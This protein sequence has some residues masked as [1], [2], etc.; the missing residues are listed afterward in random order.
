MNSLEALRQLHEKTVVEPCDP[1]VTD[2]E[3]FMR[4]NL[5]ADFGA[6]TLPDDVAVTNA[7]HY[8]T[9]CNA[10]TPL[11]DGVKELERFVDRNRESHAERCPWAWDG[12]CDCG[13]A[14]ADE[15]LAGVLRSLSASSAKG[16]SPYSCPSST[17]STVFLSMPQVSHCPACGIEVPDGW[18]K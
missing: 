14:A 1:D 16:S 6:G 4:G 13:F 11:M 8:V 7:H 17:C 10:L 18:L 12:A 3:V 9:M 2:G 15:A 5:I